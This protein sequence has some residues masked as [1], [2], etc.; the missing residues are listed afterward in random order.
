LELNLSTIVW[1]TADGR[2]PADGKE[3]PPRCLLEGVAVLLDITCDLAFVAVNITGFGLLG[4]VLIIAF[5]VVKRRL[6]ALYCSLHSAISAGE[7]YDV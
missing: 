6:V 3:L 1:L 5:L 7:W 4:I 2:K